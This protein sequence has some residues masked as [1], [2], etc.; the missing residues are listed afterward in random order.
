MNPTL[1]LLLCLLATGCS[2][3][4]ATQFSLPKERA[5]ECA[6]NCESLDMKLTAMVVIRNSAGCVCEPK[7]APPQTT[8][9]RNAAATLVGT[10]L[11]EE[12]A[13]AEPKQVR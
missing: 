7:D 1:P 11:A 2:T 5:T 13:R 12:D 3:L 10:V 6:A 8:E 9:R 4:P